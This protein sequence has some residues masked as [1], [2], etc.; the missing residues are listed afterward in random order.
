MSQERKRLRVVSDGGHCKNV[1]VYDD[2]GR[3][4]S[5]YFSRVELVADV[6]AASPVVT[7]RLEAPAVDC[8]VTGFLDDTRIGDEFRRYVPRPRPSALVW[9]ARLVVAFFAIYGALV[10]AFHFFV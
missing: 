1:K 4:V 2:A 6:R 9:V 7:L 8:D 5:R 10:F 3:E